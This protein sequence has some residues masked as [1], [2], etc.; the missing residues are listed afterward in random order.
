M[1]APPNVNRS[2]RSNRSV[3]RTQRG[4]H[5]S[6]LYRPG[7]RLTRASFRYDETP[8][9]SVHFIG[10]GQVVGSLSRQRSSL[11][12]SR[13]KLL[14]AVTPPLALPG[15][16][17][18]LAH[19]D[20][21]VTPDNAWSSWNLDPLIVVPLFLLVVLYL[22][23]LRRIWSRAGRNQGVSMRQAVA[24]LAG[25]LTLLI[26]LVSPLDPVSGALF[27]IHM[28]QHLLLV[29]I[30]APLLVYSAPLAPVLVAL[31]R[32]WRNNRAHGRHTGSPHSRTCSHEPTCHLVV[33]GGSALV[34]AHPGALRSS[35]RE[36]MVACTGTRH[37]SVN[38]PALLVGRHTAS[39]TAQAWTGTDRHLPLCSHD[40]E[41]RAGRTDHVCSID[42][43]CRAR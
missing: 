9:L 22:S 8:G 19:M 13:R 36:Q 38:C 11:W 18:V 21:P 25:I 35:P 10:N 42:L 29:V 32:P 6:E 43:V 40:P 2:R 3:S 41:Q 39:R 30:A 7:R 16:A 34:V 1:I 24:F 5:A 37:V 33:A 15:P 4:H 12:S 17:V 31:P 26:A 20:S 28:V 27:S 14:L 23:G